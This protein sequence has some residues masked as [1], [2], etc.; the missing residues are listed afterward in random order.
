MS[1][2]NHALSSHGAS[3]LCIENQK[4]LL[5]QINYGPFI[6]HWIL[7]GG[8]MNKGELPHLAA[9][10]EFKEETNLDVKLTNLLTVRYRLFENDNDNAYWVFKGDITTKLK[11]RKLSWDPTELIDVKFWNIADALNCE[12]VRPHVK[13]FINM[14][15]NNS[16]DIFFKDQND[17]IY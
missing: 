15:L 11:E 1:K 6:G 9:T 13:V 16:R 8:M 10:R 3:V 2:E 5:V 4:I 14:S 17:F 12:K 7:P